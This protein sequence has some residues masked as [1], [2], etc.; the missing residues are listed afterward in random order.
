MIVVD[1][2]ELDP[3][4]GVPEAG[5]GPRIDFMEVAEGRRRQGLCTQAIELLRQLHPGRTVFVRPP[6]DEDAFCECPAKVPSP[7]CCPAL[8]TFGPASESGQF[9]P[10]QGSPSD[11]AFPSGPSADNFSTRSTSSESGRFGG[12]DRRM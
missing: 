10:H 5:D 8:A 9:P 4:S 7:M 11:G 1:H 6:E 3:G 2:P 12:G